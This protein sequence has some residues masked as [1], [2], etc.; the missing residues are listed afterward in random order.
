VTLG[1]D[2]EHSARAGATALALA[3]ALELSYLKYEGE[4]DLK[5]M[6]QDFLR[7][8]VTLRNELVKNR[9]EDKHPPGPGEASWY[10]GFAQS[11]DQLRASAPCYNGEAWYA[12]ARYRELYPDEA[13]ELGATE[14]WLQEAEAEIMHAYEGELNEH[15]FHW[16]VQAAV[17][18]G[19]TAFADNQ[20]DRI[21]ASTPGQ[22]NRCAE[23][24]ALG[25]AVAALE[26]RG[27]DVKERLA[28]A[29]KRLAEDLTFSFA[30]QIP[31]KESACATSWSKAHV[32]AGTAAQAAGGV[33]ESSTS[34]LVRI[35]DAGHCARAMAYVQRLH[36]V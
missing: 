32:S 21:I 12:V 22:W 34:T 3:A 24:E 8:L 28:G 15:F 35:D 9:K 4:P 25:P 27:A 17:L 20:V 30:L 2:R 1:E 14:A 36:L 26:K 16:G 7:A 23:A 33:L 13:A 10:A 5:P 19:Q 6:R 11:P 18:R 29:Q 31:L